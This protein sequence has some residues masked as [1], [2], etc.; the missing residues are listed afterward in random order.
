MAKISL[1]INTYN[2]EALIEDCIKSA[3]PFADEVIVV[4][5]HSGDKTVE[6]A[7]ALGAKVYY[8]EHMG[9][10][11]P[12]RNFALQQ[13]NNEWILLLDADERIPAELGNLLKKCAEENSYDSFSIPR[14]NIQFNK[15]V[16]H[17]GWWPDYQVRFFKKDSVDWSSTIHS[18][19]QLK[20]KHYTLPVSEEHAIIHYN[21]RSIDHLLEKICRYTTHEKKLSKESLKDPYKFLGYFEKEIA[22]R[23]IREK[24]YEDEIHGFMLSKFMEF[25]RFVEL[26]RYWEENGYTE[27]T[28]IN[29]IKKIM[30]KRYK[31][32]L[33]DKI[34]GRKKL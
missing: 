31:R 16:Q 14:K 10:V 26:A 12:A 15:W 32:T 27:L 6:Y 34:L 20:Q 21:F 7:K 9:I 23:F 17:T 19:P 2:E 4:D 5:M 25:Y 22:M 8:F 18:A 13:A 1:V 11:E 29:K 33:L 30:S 3:M 28:D 24:G